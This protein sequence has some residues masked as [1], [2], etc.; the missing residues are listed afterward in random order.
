MTFALLTY[1]RGRY[2]PTVPLPVCKRV[3]YLHWEVAPS[4]YV[5]HF[6]GDRSYPALKLFQRVRHGDRPRCHQIRHRL[7]AEVYVD[8]LGVCLI[9]GESYRAVGDGDFAVRSPQG[10]SGCRNG[11]A[12]SEVLCGYVEGRR[13]RDFRFV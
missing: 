4:G 12:G 7:R 11:E 2:E 9:R 5:Q 6:R 13:V 3:L 10:F 8:V 1:Q